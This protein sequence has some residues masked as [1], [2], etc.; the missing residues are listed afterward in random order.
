M[1]EENKVS[2]R[3]KFLGWSAALLTTFTALKIFNRQDKKQGPSN[4]GGG[5]K[6]LTQDGRLVEVDSGKIYCGKQKKVTDEQLK[7]W[8]HKR[9]A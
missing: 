1:L 6:M 3:K 7:T 5:V 9:N 8:V 2:S 4:S